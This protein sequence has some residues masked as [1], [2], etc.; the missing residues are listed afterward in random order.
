MIFLKKK[1][2]RK[3]TRDMK[4]NKFGIYTFLF[5]I[6]KKFKIFYHAIENINCD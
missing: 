5:K 4:K 1:K 6:F 2:K 3:R